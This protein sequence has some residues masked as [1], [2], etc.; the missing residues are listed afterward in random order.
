MRIL[1]VDDE[2]VSRKKMEI[3]LRPYGSIKNVDSGIAAVLAFRIALQEELPFN[4]ICLDISM[5]EMSGDETLRQIRAIEKEH[6]VT[7]WKRA[8]IIMVTGVADRDTV[9]FC[10]SDGCNHFIVKPFVRET[11]V[12]KLRAMGISPMDRTT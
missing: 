5:P 2:N 11:F 4:L 3:I 8:L 10:F 6:G 1:I 12:A 9:K 7:E